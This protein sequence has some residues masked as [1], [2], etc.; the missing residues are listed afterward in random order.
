MI[1]G[2]YERDLGITP[3]YAGKSGILDFLKAGVM[4]HPRIR[5][6]KSI[7]L[8]KFN[9]HPG[10]PP[11]TRGKVIGT[12]FD[13]DE[14]RITPAYAG[15]SQIVRKLLPGVGDHPRIRGEKTVWKT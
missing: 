12:V 4:D 10:S 15:K 3:A 1:S 9:L 8:F 5:G 11:H 14:S 7:W 6:E 2:L 13:V